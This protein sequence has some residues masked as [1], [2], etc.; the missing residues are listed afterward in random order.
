MAS[1]TGVLLA[2]VA[3]M[4]TLPLVAALRD[5]LDVGGLVFEA[6]EVA[7]GDATAGDMEMGKEYKFKLKPQKGAGGLADL[8]FSA[9]NVPDG[10]RELVITWIGDPG[11]MASR[12]RA[13]TS[14]ELADQAMEI[15]VKVGDYIVEID[16]VRGASSM[17][18][19][20][21]A[22]SEDPTHEFAFSIRRGKE[23]GK[24]YMISIPVHE[25][26]KDYQLAMR[27]N[28]QKCRLVKYL[29]SK[30]TVQVVMVGEAWWSMQLDD[31]WL[32]T[33]LHEQV[34]RRARPAKR[35]PETRNGKVVGDT[36]TIRAANDPRMSLNDGKMCKLI[37]FDAEGKCK[38][39]MLTSGKTI[40]VHP[41]LLVGPGQFWV[42]VD[43]HKAAATEHLPGETKLE[44]VTNVNGLRLS[45]DE[46]YT[47]MQ[48][49]EVLQNLWNERC[50]IVR[51][52]EHELDKF[53]QEAMVALSDGNQWRVPVR[54]LEKGYEKL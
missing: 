1:F 19:R 15:D 22:E 7:D 54:F 49:W 46:T 8:G 38:C 36:Y 5:S 6:S 34:Q 23:V 25:D 26:G 47:I 43:S 32:A 40:K 50:Q 48:D 14:W 52:C 9:E 11:P 28:G 53:G 29:D 16:G 2:P 31:R 17:S 35:S 45:V 21:A 24:E 18:M 27:Y 13:S 41:D 3:A 10:G 42:P 20:L 51:F 4:V 30:H 44:T 37:E 12:M 33:V 39:N